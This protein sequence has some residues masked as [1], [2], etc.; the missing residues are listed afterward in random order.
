MANI[1]DVLDSL[2]ITFTKIDHPAV[3]TVAEASKVDMRMDAAE[4]KNLFLRN[5]KGDTHYLYIVESSRVVDLKKL[6]LHLQ[7]KSLSFASPDRL[8]YHLGVMPGSVSPFALI[9][10]ED[11]SVRVLV[12]S[13]LFNHEKIG[14]H[15]NINTAT[16]VISREG[17]KKFLNSTGNAVEYLE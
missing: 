1:Y 12:D 7:E 16:L 3:F 10:N 17:F 14:F 2:H 13:G 11:K 8:M 5:R 15:P 4:C 6:A 9:N